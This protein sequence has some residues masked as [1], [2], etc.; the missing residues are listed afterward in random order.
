MQTSRRSFV[1]SCATKCSSAVPNGANE[2]SISPC[3]CIAQRRWKMAGK[4][5]R[6]FCEAKS[7]WT[8]QQ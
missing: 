5:S 2:R 4:F 8:F 1:A 6:S 3:A 7:R